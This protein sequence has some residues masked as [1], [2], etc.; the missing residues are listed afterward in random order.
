MA[1]MDDECLDSVAL[2]KPYQTTLNFELWVI[3]VQYI[4]SI[5][6]NSGPQVEIHHPPSICEIAFLRSIQTKG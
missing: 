3:N 1:N 5:G 6:S 4:L 2:N